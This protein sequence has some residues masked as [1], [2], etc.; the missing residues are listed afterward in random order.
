[1][2]FAKTTTLFSAALTIMCS[3][4]LTGGQ[5]ASWLKNGVWDAYP[6]SA[7][8]NRLK[9]GESAT[10]MM[11]SS[12]IL[13]AELINNQVITNWLLRI[14]AIAPLLIASA[15]LIA[16]YMLITVIENKYPN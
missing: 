2:I 15:L 5:M 9:T 1:M 12:D 7:V 13:D 4:F 10:Y 8:I 16:F 3:V 11:A 14:P 6:I